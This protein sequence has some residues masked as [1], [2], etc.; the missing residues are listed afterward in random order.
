MAPDPPRSQ[1]WA[2]PAW[3][4]C[5]EHLRAHRCPPVGGG[6][7]KGP[8]PLHGGRSCSR[9]SWCPASVPQASLRWAAQAQRGCTETSHLLPG[10][11]HTC[12]LYFLPISTLRSS[13]EYSTGHAPTPAFESQLV[14]Q[15]SLRHDVAEA[16]CPRKGGCRLVTR[17]RPRLSGCPG[18]V[19][20]NNEIQPES[21]HGTEP[22]CLFSPH[23]SRTFFRLSLTAVTLAHLRVPGP[24]SGHCPPEWAPAV[25]S[26]SR[27]GGASGGSREGDVWRRALADPLTGGICSV[28]LAPVGVPPEAHCS[29]ACD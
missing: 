17:P 16:P 12:I 20:C 19:L 26:W 14:T 24:S 25:L 18:N 13:C 4:I 2:R 29:P 10:H 6:V 28:T 22:S 23:W 11:S 8:A 5:A 21:A 3:C 9:C 1:L 15:C 27:A 7:R